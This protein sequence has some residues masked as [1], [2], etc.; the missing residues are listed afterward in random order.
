MY[1]NNIPSTVPLSPSLQSSDG[2]ITV[3]T[4]PAMESTY[5]LYYISHE[6]VEKMEHENCSIGSKTNENDNEIII[7]ILY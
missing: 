5:S 2:S 4:F 7:V 1:T 6:A 3:V